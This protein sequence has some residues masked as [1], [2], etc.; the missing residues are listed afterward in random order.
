[1]VS[2]HKGRQK[3]L[4]IQAV[5]NLPQA[6]DRT[7]PNQPNQLTDAQPTRRPNQT[8]AFIVLAVVGGYVGS[9]FTAFNTWI[10]LARKRWSGWFSF[11][12]LEVS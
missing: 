12:V 7:Q 2:L 3:G 10:C 5:G 8:W 6:S 1:L 11:R 9:L 4:D